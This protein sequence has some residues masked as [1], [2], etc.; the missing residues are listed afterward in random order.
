MLRIALVVWA[1]SKQ[2]M[3]PDTKHLRYGQNHL[4]MCVD[5]LAIHIDYDS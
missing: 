3:V 5:G 1:G 4:P 2:L